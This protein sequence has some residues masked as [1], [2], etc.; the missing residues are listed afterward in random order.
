MVWA[1]SQVT[2]WILPSASST[3]L[4]MV[5]LTL[6]VP[7]FSAVA[8]LERSMA[9]TMPRPCLTAGASGAGAALAASSSVV[10]LATLSVSSLASVAALSV[11]SLTLVSTSAV[12]ASSFFCRS[13]LPMKPTTASTA[14]TISRTTVRVKPFFIGES[15]FKLWFWI[16]VRQDRLC[17]KI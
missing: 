4:Q 2:D 17:V 7:A 8:S 15:S 13:P 6:A 14:A 10:R 9:V 12:A 11:T 16:I 1:T 5:V 3:R